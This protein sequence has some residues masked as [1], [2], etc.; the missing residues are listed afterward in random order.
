MNTLNMFN[1][2]TT[3]ERFKVVLSALA[4]PPLLQRFPCSSV[5]SGVQL[6]ELTSFYVPLKNI[7]EKLFEEAYLKFHREVLLIPQVTA[8]LTRKT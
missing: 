4:T 2:A 7:D 5:L 8:L 6:M 1:N 3:M